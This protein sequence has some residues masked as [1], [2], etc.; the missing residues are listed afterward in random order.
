MQE[1]PSR[2]WLC[3]CIL[4]ALP[5]AAHAIGLGEFTVRSTLGS[6][7]RAEIEFIAVTEE[8]L[9][10]LTARIAEPDAFRQA[11]IRYSLALVGARLSIERRAD[12]RPYVQIVST[13]R[14]DELFLDLLVELI[15]PQGHLVRQFAALFDPPELNAGTPA[16]RAAPAVEL[17]LATWLGSPMLAVA[18]PPARTKPAAKAPPA[19]GPTVASRQAGGIEYGPVRAGET[20]SQIASGIKAKGVPLEP[21]LAALYRA[22]PDAF[23]SDMN[24]LKAGA[25]LRIPEEYLE[26]RASKPGTARATSSP[27]ARKDAPAEVLRLSKG[28]ITDGGKAGDG[29]DV[30]RRFSEL[31][32]ALEAGLAELEKAVTEANER[33]TQLEQTVMNLRRE[34][35][36]PKR[37][38]GAA[39]PSIAS[40][41]APET[42][43]GAPTPDAAKSALERIESARD[44]GEMIAA[45]P[46][47][48]EQ[49]APAAQPTAGGP[50]LAEAETP[51][52]AA[53]EKAKFAGVAKPSLQL[54][55]RFLIDPLLLAGGGF[56]ALLGGAGYWSIR[57][58]RARDANL[59]A[60]MAAA[61]IARAAP[62]TPEDDQDE[63]AGAARRKLRSVAD[64]TSVRQLP[65]S[66]R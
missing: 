16:P 3:A 29:K 59:D 55:H 51:T 34:V 38:L 2:A 8:E 32:R 27:V 21:M 10:S 42:R 28:D 62:V 37:P 65:R 64:V 66:K 12:G 35:G 58:R 50:P 43:P 47:G 6:P 7:L 17:P 14:V 36:L 54:M 23:G 45:T 63:P 61:V 13:R 49:S 5:W 30:P 26:A 20:L 33:V 9:V 11:N 56:L 18:T 24:V 44:T 15:W 40:Q 60:R 57:R 41:A 46:G 52:G 22:N 31:E 25:M 19:P 39:E 1:T 53:A 4:L 48:G